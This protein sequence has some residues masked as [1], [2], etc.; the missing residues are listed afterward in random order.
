M[1]ASSSAQHPQTSGPYTA[2]T[3]RRRDDHKAKTGNENEESYILALHTD[4]EH[5]KTMTALRNK[6]FPPRINKLEAHIALF[7]ALPGSELS[8]IKQDISDIA[9]LKQSFSISASQPF[10]M[11]KGV[12][13]RIS[14]TE[15]AKTIF[16]ELKQRWE[17]FLSQQDRSFKAHYTIQNKVDDESVV[18]DTI[19]DVKEHFRGSNGTVQ[20]L[21]L[22]KYDR[23][24]WRKEQNFP[25]GPSRGT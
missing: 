2:E 14:H 9:S 19:K 15:P 7:R 20:G 21:S 5:H 10:R 23:G 4:S 18:D 11:G 1:A 12:G 24:Y 22:Y 16:E 6:H 17:P 13:I 25:F 3:Y 8:R